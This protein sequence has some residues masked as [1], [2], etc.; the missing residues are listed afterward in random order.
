MP[1][2]SPWMRLI[3]TGRPSIHSP[4]TLARERSAGSGEP[5]FNSAFDALPR[6]RQVE[7]KESRLGT[8]RPIPKLQ[9]TQRCTRKWSPG[10]RRT[11]SFAVAGFAAR[12]FPVGVVLAVLASSRLHDSSPFHNCTPRLRL[13]C[14]QLRNLPSRGRGQDFGLHGLGATRKRP[15]RLPVRLRAHRSSSHCVSFTHLSAAGFSDP[16]LS[17]T[18]EPNA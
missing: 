2:S 11:L 9:T 5:N 10:S 16:R 12:T 17:Q 3:S 4:W 14:T 18:L 7:P 15:R 13:N 8:G 1:P 6:P